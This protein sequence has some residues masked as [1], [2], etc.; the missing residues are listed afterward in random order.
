[1]VH[2]IVPYFPATDSQRGRER[3]RQPEGKP[4]VR[5]RSPLYDT[6]ELNGVKEEVDGLFCE[7]H[8]EGRST[9]VGRGEARVAEKQ[10]IRRSMGSRQGGW[11]GRT[12]IP[13][14]ERR[15]MSLGARGWR[16]RRRRRRQLRSTTGTRDLWRGTGRGDVKVTT[17]SERRETGPDGDV[18]DNL[19]SHEHLT[20]DRRDR[21]HSLAHAHA[22][23]NG[24]A[25]RGSVQDLMKKILATG[26]EG[27]AH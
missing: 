14:E 25:G 27:A 26:G 11:A 13:G 1:M 18:D 9:T 4:A 3:G 5:S 19:G 15:P 21:H 24:R 12:R 16:R 20:D 22:H 6:A 23:G 10:R 7:A 2:G 8:I 17:W